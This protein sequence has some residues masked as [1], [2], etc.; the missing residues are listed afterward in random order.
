MIAFCTA[1]TL[2]SMIWCSL[3]DP[4]MKII[5]IWRIN[6]HTLRTL[7][8]RIFNKYEVLCKIT[9]YFRGFLFKATF[10]QKMFLVLGALSENVSWQV[11]FIQIV[12]PLSRL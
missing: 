3:T 10:N 7:E 9:P 4:S 11:T 1:I 2:N 6:D 12:N 8:Q 5:V